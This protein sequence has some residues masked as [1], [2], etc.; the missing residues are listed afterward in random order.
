VNLY[1]LLNT[2]YQVILFYNIRNYENYMDQHYLII[3]NLYVFYLIMSK[4][5]YTLVL[6]SNFYIGPL[7]IIYMDSMIT[8]DIINFLLLSIYG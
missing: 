8:I 3:S 5:R 2:T 6:K 1:Y 4:F 7:Y